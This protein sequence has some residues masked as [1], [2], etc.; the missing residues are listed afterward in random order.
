MNTTQIL[1]IIEKRKVTFLLSYNVFNLFLLFIMERSSH[2]NMTDMGDFLGLLMKSVI[3][4]FAL[5]LFVAGIVASFL[6]I[7]SN[8]DANSNGYLMVCAFA[9]CGLLISTIFL[10]YEYYLEDNGI[11]ARLGSL[12]ELKLEEI[13]NF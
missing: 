2:T 13:F 11:I 3:F 6:I 4:Y 12:L 8:N 5:I 9:L 7:F 1:A 10:G